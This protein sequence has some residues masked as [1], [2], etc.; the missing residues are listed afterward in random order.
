MEQQEDICSVLIEEFLL[1]L[2]LGGLIVVK[3]GMFRCHSF[4]QVF[5]NWVWFSSEFDDLS[6]YIIRGRID[7]LGG[8]G[9]ILTEAEST[10]ACYLTFKILRNLGEMNGVG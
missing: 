5:G 10:V 2:F 6:L 9:W 8:N 4:S 7:T 3:L 1:F